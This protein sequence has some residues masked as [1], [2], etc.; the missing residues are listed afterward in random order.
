MPKI[1]EAL[2]KFVEKNFCYDDYI[3]SMDKY[4]KNLW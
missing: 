4:L 1:R 3:I 2:Q